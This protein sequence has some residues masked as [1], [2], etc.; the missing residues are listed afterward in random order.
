MQG[1]C[2]AGSQLES[3]VPKAWERKTS[4]SFLPSA[5]KGW[6]GGWPCSPGKALPCWVRSDL[7]LR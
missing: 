5:L 1:P 2:P 6:A 3:C 7:G 4:F